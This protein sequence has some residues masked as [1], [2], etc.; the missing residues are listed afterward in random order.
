MSNDPLEPTALPVDYNTPDLRRPCM[1]A[2]LDDPVAAARIG[3]VARQQVIENHST[4]KVASD[5]FALYS[6]VN[7]PRCALTGMT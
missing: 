2:M 4:V 6:R 7:A 3:P 1:A 5:S